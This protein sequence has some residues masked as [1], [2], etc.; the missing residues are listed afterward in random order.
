MDICRMSIYLAYAMAIYT[1]ASVYYIIRTRSVG[2]D[3]IKSLDPKQLKLKKDADNI[4][5][6]IFYQGLVG[7]AVVLYFYYP[8]KRAV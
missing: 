3:F 7:S 5:L 1:A 4:R 2:T 6:N 8:F